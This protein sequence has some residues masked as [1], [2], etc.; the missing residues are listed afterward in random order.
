MLEFNHQLLTQLIIDNGNSQG[1]RLIGQK[2]AIVCALQVQLQVYYDKNINKI[3][4]WLTTND[5]AVNLIVI[6][7]KSF[8]LNQIQVI[9]MLENAI[10]EAAAKSFK[11]AIV[12]VKFLQPHSTDRIESFRTEESNKHG[13]E[14][15]TSLAKKRRCKRQKQDL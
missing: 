10:L 13:F 6:T 5:W 11:V 15:V 3:I 12:D 4:S 8:T 9:R 7:V 1:A 14:N 2:T